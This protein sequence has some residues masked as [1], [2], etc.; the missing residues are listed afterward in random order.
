MVDIYNDDLQ[1]RI[2]RVK[3]TAHNRD[4]E[5]VT[6]VLTSDLVELVTALE[7]FDNIRKWADERDLLSRDKVDRQ[8]V[9][10]LEELGETSRAILKGDQPEIVDGI[11]D[12][13]VVLTI[14]SKQLGLNL[15]ECVAASYNVIKNR[16]GKTVNGVF[17][18]DQ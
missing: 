3:G 15:E 9:K 1:T 6:T 2:K 11:G 7:V 14:L 16:T 13:A 10:L 12:V 17:V 5:G 18:K 4:Y 8:I